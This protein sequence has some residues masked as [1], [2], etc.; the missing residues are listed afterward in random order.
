MKEIK[1][2]L[3]W[4]EKE[5]EVKVN[6]L[7][8]LIVKIGLI[9]GTL[10]LNF[11]PGDP[12]ILITNYARK[13]I[14]EHLLQK[15]IE[16]GGL[17]L[18]NVYSLNREDENSYAVVIS[19]SIPSVEFKST[20][21]SLSLGID[22]WNAARPYLGKGMMVAGWYHSHPGFGA[23]FSSTDR[24]TQKHFFREPYHVGL[25]VDPFREEEMWFLG[26]DSTEAKYKFDLL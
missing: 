9:D 7:Q 19:H 12:I 1:K 3:T 18:G 6:S 4:K 2:Q 24:Y 16:L 8:E 10:I 17:L 25:V 20:T 22:V 15:K 11:S 23:F 21:V 13:A 5:P 14:Y 26:K